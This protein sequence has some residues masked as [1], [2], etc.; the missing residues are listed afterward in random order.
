VNLTDQTKRGRKPRELLQ[1][2]AHRYDVVD[3]LVDVPRDLRDARLEL[4]GKQIVERALR[5]LDLRAEHCLLSN[6]HRDEEIRAR[7]VPDLAVQTADRLV[8]ARE[9]GDQTIRL[10]LPCRSDPLPERTANNP[11]RPRDHAATGPHPVANVEHRLPRC[12]ATLV[13]TATNRGA[14]T[15]HGDSS[16]RGYPPIPSAP[17]RRSVER[18]RRAISGRER[19]K[20]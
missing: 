1:A 17:R 3:D 2:V 14:L 9:Q 18:V 12:T 20:R 5:P 4:H 8:R 13:R 6:V 19:G 16:R 11:G 15:E 7:H 10:G